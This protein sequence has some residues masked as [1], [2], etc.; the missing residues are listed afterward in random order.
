MS[1]PDGL[2]A[3]SSSPQDTC[4]MRDLSRASLVLASLLAVVM[5]VVDVAAAIPD[6][7]PQPR[8]VATGT[9]APQQTGTLPTQPIVPAPRP[10]ATGTPPITLLFFGD[11]ISALP[12]YADRVCA[13]L[14]CARQNTESGALSG[15]T[16][17]V[18][19]AVCPTLPC[20]VTS[21]SW[22]VVPYPTDRL[23][24]EYG[25]NDL[26]YLNGY[27]DRFNLGSWAMAWD[28]LYRQIDRPEDA[29]IVGLPV[30][31]PRIG[32]CAIPW[33]SSWEDARIQMDGITQIE[34]M[35]HGARFVSLEGMTLDMLG[36][37]HV[38]PDSAGADFMASR[39]L[40][41]LTSARK[42]G[43]RRD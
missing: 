41:A 35:Q 33:A 28:A 7:M 6:P 11:S 4:Q 30:I 43:F 38:H 29:V 17:M 8:T 20:G 27:P 12:G 1:V 25:R 36:A 10:T 26:T 24:I 22:R 32:V 18:V 21:Y 37:D 39:V 34:A 15:T 42:E 40:M 19:P 14:A 31:D 23:I 13:A 2:A 3:F 16:L 5:C 9:V